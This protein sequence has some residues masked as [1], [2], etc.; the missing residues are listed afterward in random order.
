CNGIFTHNT[1]SAI[2]ALELAM[3]QGSN[4][5][6]AL[7]LT[8]NTRSFDIFKKDIRNCAS[9]QRYPPENEAAIKKMIKTV[10]KFNTYVKFTKDYESNKAIFTKKYS[11]CYI[12]LDEIHGVSN[13]SK[14]TKVYSSL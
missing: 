3:E 2:G 5:Q 11:N 13:K 1:C 4:I 10:F 12:I 7:V 14:K 6:R 8:R 9:K